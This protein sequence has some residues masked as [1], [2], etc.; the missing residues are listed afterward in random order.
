MG[1][2][3]C[4][5]H[6]PRRGALLDVRFCEEDGAVKRTGFIEGAHGTANGAA[7]LLVAE[8]LLLSQS[9]QEDAVAQGSGYIVQK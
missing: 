9:D 8:L 4:L 1:G 3:A 2:N 6:A 7:V 5:P